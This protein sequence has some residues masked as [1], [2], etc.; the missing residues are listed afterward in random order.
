MLKVRVFAG[1]LGAR[2]EWMEFNM[3]R[4]INPDTL[5]DERMLGAKQV[6]CTLADIL[7][8]AARECELIGWL[9]E[10]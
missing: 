7:A 6:T 5:P 8:L 9:R 10:A 3:Q 2:M 1:C 4:S